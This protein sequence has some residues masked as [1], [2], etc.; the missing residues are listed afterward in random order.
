MQ[1]LRVAYLHGLHA[2]CMRIR[3]AAWRIKQR[4]TCPCACPQGLSDSDIK[5]WV[6]APHGAEMRNPLLMKLI[7]SDYKAL[8]ACLASEAAPQVGG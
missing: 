4:W 1:G 5:Q 8:A 2:A 7:S 3:M 6:F